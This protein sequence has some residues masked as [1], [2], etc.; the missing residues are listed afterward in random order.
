MSCR[1][2]QPSPLV[3]LCTRASFSIRIN[4]HVDTM[5]NYVGPADGE[6]NAIGNRLGDVDRLI[7][8]GNRSVS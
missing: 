1:K 5:Y 7:D 8:S 2:E 3:T 6:K 4:R